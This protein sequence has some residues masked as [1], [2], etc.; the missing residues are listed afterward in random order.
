MPL[1]KMRERLPEQ[2]LSYRP[3]SLDCL[4]SE[5][6]PGSV[7]GGKKRFAGIQSPPDMSN[8]RTRIGLGLRTA[9]PLRVGPDRPRLG[10]TTAAT[11]I[12]CA[13]SGV[14]EKTTHLA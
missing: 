8:S 5:E 12:V 9:A 2:R 3:V 10:R 13:H 7:E 6:R 4:S 1:L 11:K 14:S